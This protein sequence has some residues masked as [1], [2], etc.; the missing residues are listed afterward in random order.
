MERKKLTNEK[1]RKQDGR[2]ERKIETK[3]EGRKED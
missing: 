3:K 2:E 1:R